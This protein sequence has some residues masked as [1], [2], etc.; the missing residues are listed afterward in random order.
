M[1]ALVERFSPCLRIRKW[2]H[3]QLNFVG[4]RLNNSSME[5]NFSFCPHCARSGKERLI[6]PSTGR[7]PLVSRSDGGSY[8]LYLEEA[9][10]LNPTGKAKEIAGLFRYDLDPAGVRADSSLIRIPYAQDGCDM[11]EALEDAAD[12]LAEV[13][14]GGQVPCRV[15]ILQ[16][17]RALVEASSHFGKAE[18]RLASG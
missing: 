8:H 6:Q 11:Q 7:T 2:N 16:A 14:E 18:V 17:G 1:D 15:Y 4:G 3:S 13:L 9:N 12:R 5:K 10:I